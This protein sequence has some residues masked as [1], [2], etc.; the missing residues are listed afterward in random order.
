MFAVNPLGKTGVICDVCCL[1]VH[2]EISSYMATEL[3]NKDHFCPKC[4][5]KKKEVHS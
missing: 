1:I 5:E 4:F 3:A 2:H